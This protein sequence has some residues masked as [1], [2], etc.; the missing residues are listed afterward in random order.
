MQQ[1]NKEHNRT[2]KN[3]NHKTQRQNLNHKGESENYNKILKS[4][5]K[6]HN[7]TTKHR[8]IFIFKK[9]MYFNLYTLYIFSLEFFI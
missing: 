4:N 6:S 5:S 2:T 9:K 7:A 1:Q 8:A 3:K